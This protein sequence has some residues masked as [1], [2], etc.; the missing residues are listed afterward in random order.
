MPP[1]YY[2]S[3]SSLV[4]RDNNILKGSSDVWAS[5]VANIAPLLVLV[6]EKHVKGYFKCMC[7]ERHYF[8]F[9]AGPIGLVTTLVS[10]IR[11]RRYP[12]LLRLIG[13]Q[14][15]SKA[16]V[17]ADITSVSLGEVSI[18]LKNRSLEQTIS[19]DASHLAHFYVRG[20]LAG[21]G[22]EMLRSRS[23]LVWTM[24][25]GVKDRKSVV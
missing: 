10:L 11:L 7:R 2:D 12:L 19:P 8:L 1:S 23:Q 20:A 13:R 5:F 9:A 4:Q 21:S 6:G 15:E 17:L 3:G 25:Q 22:P 24:R 14:F 18:E 16:E